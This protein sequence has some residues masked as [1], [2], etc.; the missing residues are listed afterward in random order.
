MRRYQQ[1]R[2][3]LL[4]RRRSRSAE[5]SRWL[6]AVSWRSRVRCRG[7]NGGC[8]FA[9][10]GGRGAA[11]ARQF[12]TAA[13]AARPRPWEVCAEVRT[14]TRSETMPPPTPPIRARPN[15]APPSPPRS[16]ACGTAKRAACMRLLFFDAF[17]LPLPPML[18]RDD[19][20]K[21]QVRGSAVK[22]TDFGPVG[23]ARPQ[24]RRRH[25]RTPQSAPRERA[26]RTDTHP[27]KRAPVV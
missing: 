27:Q 9:G 7:W 13:A 22:G 10:G 8:R 26:R 4:L 14:G 23:K 12:I 6:A 17:F 16:W 5:V 1:Q 15:R 21:Q 2:R 3:G 24:Q 19:S 25:A 18:E 20:S 11:A